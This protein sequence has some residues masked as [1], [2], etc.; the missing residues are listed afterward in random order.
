MR[1]SIA[2]GA[3]A[4]LAML[5]QTT[6]LS[7]IP[8]LPV[9]PDLI[10]VLVVYL[11]LRH[12]GLGGALG[13]FLLGYF[14]DTFSGTTLGVNAFALTAVYGGVSLIARNLWIEGGVPAMLVVFAGALGRELMSVFF[15]AVLAARAPV[16]HQAMLH[17]MVAAVV[18]AAVT[19]AIFAMVTWEKRLLG[20]G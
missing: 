8:R 6:V 15:A 1:S 18:A 13:A 7:W 9:V 2:L 20:V 19:P 12:P 16:W 11:A 17:G 3:A 4:V 10:V 5:V 14:L